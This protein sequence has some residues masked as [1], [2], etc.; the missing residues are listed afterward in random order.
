MEAFSF[1]PQSTVVDIVNQAMCLVYENEESLF[2]P[3]ELGA[4][5]HD[6]LMLQYP[7]PTVGREWEEIAQ[8]CLRVREYM[9]P[10]LEYSGHKFR[11]R[12][13]LKVGLSW[14]DMREVRMTEDASALAE[15]IR[16][17]FSDVSRTPQPQYVEMEEFEV[18]EEASDSEEHARLL[19]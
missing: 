12:S 5:V 1:K 15:A 10:E 7:I 17:A 2:I 8:F 6:S 3:V 13:D 19:A 14:G 16:T 11:L 9:R 4:Q 18:V